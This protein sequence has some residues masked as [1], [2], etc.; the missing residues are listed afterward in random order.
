MDWQR[1]TGR[2]VMINRALTLFC[3]AVLLFTAQT[4]HA[5]D[6]SLDELKRMIDSSAHLTE[7]DSAK[8]QMC[9]LLTSRLRQLIRRPYPVI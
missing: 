4:T 2:S 5:G 9:Q 8:P 1:Y 7:T 3:F 6:V